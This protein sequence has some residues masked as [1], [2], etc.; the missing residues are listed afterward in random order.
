MKICLSSLTM[1]KQIKP[2]QNEI[3]CHTNYNDQNKTNAH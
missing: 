1:K 3:S 2:Q